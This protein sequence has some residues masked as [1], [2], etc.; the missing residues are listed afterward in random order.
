M[1]PRLSIQLCTALL[2]ACLSAWAAAQPVV[3]KIGHAASLT[4]SNAHNGKDTE[5]GVRLAID[6]LNA[7]KLSIGGR[8]LQFELLSEDDAGDPKAGTA[9]AQRMVDT[10]V[11]GVIGHWNSG[12]T[13]PA[14]RIYR[15]AGIPQ[16]SPAATN[17]K[18]TRQGFETAFRMVADDTVIGSL[19]GR[20]AVGALKAARIVIIDDRTAYGQGV[21]DEFQKAVRAAGGTVI[22]REFTTDRSTDFAAI[23][24]KIKGQ[25][26]DLIFLGAM[27]A[28]AGPMVRQMKQLGLNARV[29]GGDGICTDDLAKLAG[30]ALD[31][32]NVVC[33]E[34]GGVPAERQASLDDWK[35]QF[36]SRTG[37]SV[38][39]YA[40]HA[41]DA[42]MTL[43]AAM[44]KAGSTDPAKVL[45][46]LAKIEHNGVIGRVAF[47]E[48]GDIRGGTLMLFTYAKGQRQPLG[49]LR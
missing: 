47:D 42:T 8:M 48:K 2:T 39:L 22:G 17:P 7:R 45:P 3:V 11:A 36:R 41:Y 28:V 10:K 14:S 20:H 23:L 27:D 49:L 15:D 24:T 35:K 32:I 9:V 44:Q 31:T 25:R 12:T 21:A 6:D 13:I 1:S 46:V 26:P 33:A 30:E 37:E 40:P 19:L 38:V 29:M 43:A 16:L 18:Y 4:G 5:R 34:P